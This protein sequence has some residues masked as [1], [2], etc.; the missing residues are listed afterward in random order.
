MAKDRRDDGLLSICFPCSSLLAI[1]SFSLHYFSSIEEYTR[2]SGDV[3]LAKE[4]YDKYISYLA[5]GITSIV[6]VFQP[7]VISLGGG[8]S[9]EGQ[10]LIDDLKPLITDEQ[11]GGDVVKTAEIRIA[12]LK[13]DAG[14]IGASAL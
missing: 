10:S 11:Y 4:V 14:I 5:N 3:S 13:N 12:K 7:E 1:P 6:N 8:I 2:Y 9:N